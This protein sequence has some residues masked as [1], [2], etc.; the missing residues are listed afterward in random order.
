[1]TRMKWA[2]VTIRLILLAPAVFASGCRAAAEPPVLDALVNAQR[3]GDALG[4]LGK[5][6]W[7]A[8][9]QLDWLRRHGEVGHVPLQYEL[10]KRLY[11]ND[12]EESLKWYARS[13]LARTLDV[14]ECADDTVSLPRRVML[15]NLVES[16]QKAGLADPKRFNQA[17]A[18]AVDWDERRPTP[19]PA[20]WICG[21]STPPTPEGYVLPPETRKQKRDEARHNMAFKA[22]M[23]AAEDKAIEA[24]K[25]AN[26]PILDSGVPPP[27]GFK[28]DE[29]EFWLDND[30]V[31]FLGY[32]V[33]RLWTDPETGRPTPLVNTLY[34]WDTRSNKVEAVYRGDS[35]S[36][37]CV[38]RGYV[39]F[40]LADEGKG[41]VFEGQWGALTKR[42]ATD[43]DKKGRIFDCKTTRGVPVIPGV[44]QTWKLLPEH[45]YLVASYIDDNWQRQK[46]RFFPAG[47]SESID[48]SFPELRIDD[49]GEWN[50]RYSERRN[51]YMVPGQY[52]GPGRTGDT[53]ER[54]WPP[55][56]DRFF[57]WFHPDGRVEKEILPL[58]YCTKAGPGLETA[59]GYLKGGC[60]AAPE[61]D[62][63]VESGSP[64]SPDGCKVTFRYRGKQDKYQNHI[65][66]E[67]LINRPGY[68]T[69][70]M[71]NL[72]QGGQK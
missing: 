64:V 14:A 18:E 32:D 36:E 5:S 10:S 62:E 71:I 52:V 58:R 63:I 21:E 33:K 59:R 54:G 2:G 70:K 45:G 27:D 47:N 68:Y 19:P 15:D 44:R 42:P 7:S 53:T 22:R 28:S 16:V 6:G 66:P 69:L 35:V 24:G 57:Y 17:I 23:R 29:K 34:L 30:R 40:R 60:L 67:L 72:C 4:A 12:F 11:P 43:E 41:W 65:L 61:G 51:A 8:T 13:R 20:K 1:M 48:V 38:F 9:Q 31:L 49:Y 56:G 46:V 37:L 39:H 55:Y 50:I 3:Y 26:Y 25:R